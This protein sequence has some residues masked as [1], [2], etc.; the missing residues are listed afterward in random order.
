[1]SIVICLF[2]GITD[3]IFVSCGIQVALRWITRWEESYTKHHASMFTLRFTNHRLKFDT[4]RQ[5]LLLVKGILVRKV[6]P[7]CPV[8][9]FQV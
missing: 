4:E 5:D 9:A 3:G 7:F 8:L 2:D 1:M 6:L